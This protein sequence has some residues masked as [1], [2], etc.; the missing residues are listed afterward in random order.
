M[1]ASESGRPWW[2]TGSASRPLILPQP[3][4]PCTAAALLRAQAGQA[5]GYGDALVVFKEAFVLP[6][7]A[8][9][10]AVVGWRTWRQRAPR[11]G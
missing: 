9:T 3:A 11:H 1:S 10:L 4:P 2:G 7:T 5:F 6:L 8:V